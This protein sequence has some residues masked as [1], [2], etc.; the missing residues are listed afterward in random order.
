VVWRDLE[1]YQ[2][3]TGNNFFL[4]VLLLSQ[5]LSASL[6]FGLILG[7]LLLFPLSADPLAKIPRERLELWPLSGPARVAL[8]VASIGLSPAAWITVAVVV[9]TSR[10]TVALVFLGLAVCAQALSVTGSRLAARMPAWDLPRRV[11]SLPGRLGGLVR[12][13]LRQMLRVL[14]FYVALLVSVAGVAFRV[15]GRGGD[16]EAFPV[17]AVLVVLALSTYAQCLFGLDWPDGWTRYHL[18]P[19]RGWF[20]LLAK[21]MAFLAVAAVLTAGLDLLAGVTAALAALAVGHHA[22]VRTPGAQQ[23]W[24]FTGG[25]LF[26]AGLVQVVVM[27][28][29]GV[30][31]HRAGTLYLALALAGY[32]GSLWFYGRDWDRTRE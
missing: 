28:G 2:S 10:V 9:K 20:I 31:V 24:R 15:A 1:S 23:R 25:T 22:S 17:L 18:S 19:L 29:V 13:D 16:A 6:F 8:R 5:Q 30:G 11:P 14:D 32:A 12:K 4:F 21:G 3:L 26:P 27:F 7:L